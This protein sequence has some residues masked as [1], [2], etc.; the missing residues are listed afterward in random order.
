[1]GD[2]PAIQ[3]AL[4]SI[5]TKFNIKKMGNVNNYV[6]ATIERSRDRITIN[7]KRMIEELNNDFDLGTQK[8]KT[9]AAPGMTLSKVHEDDQALSQQEQ[10][11]YRSGVGKLLYLAKLSRPDI[12]NSVRELA[13]Y[14]DK[15]GREH[16]QAMER[17][18]NY[19]ADTKDMNLV[20]VQDDSNEHGF[21]I[22]VDSD[23]AK[24]RDD[25]KSVTGYVILFHGNP[26]AWKSKGQSCVT[27]STTEAEYIA[28]SQAVAE[29]L[30]LKQVIESIGLEVKLPI[31]VNEDN[32]GA[33]DLASNW[34]T[35]SNIKHIDVRYHFVRELLEDGIIQINYV[36]SE[37]NVA[38]IFTKNLGEQLFEKHQNWLMWN[39]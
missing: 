21:E 39:K 38:D 33:I 20:L 24:C 18:L 28:L 15:A 35:N 34:S 30:F 31:I 17:L 1:M 11:Y 26:V 12:A 25:R 37:E 3:D 8:W 10:K 13:R 4:D 27:L 32:T 2:K 9:P 23:Y 6:G 19:V 22:Y 36:K 7:Q 5:K 29:C 16:L 14:M